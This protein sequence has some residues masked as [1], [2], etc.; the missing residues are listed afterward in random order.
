MAEKDFAI[1][2]SNNALHYP[3]HT[4]RGGKWDDLGAAFFWHSI[5]LFLY[6]LGFGFFFFYF[7]WSYCSR[8]HAVGRGGSWLARGGKA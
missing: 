4:A 7:F 3:G 8:S 6:P 1:D 5:W 2:S